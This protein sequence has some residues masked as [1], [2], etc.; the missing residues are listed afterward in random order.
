MTPTGQDSPMDIFEAAK[1]HAD[2]TAPAP[3]D[4]PVAAA[5][6]AT[7]FGLF[8]IGVFFAIRWFGVPEW[9]AWIAA[10]AIYGLIAYGDCRLGWHHH[11]RAYQQRLADLRAETPARSLH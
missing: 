5:L 6:T 7:A 2:G 4:R 10:A 9:V 11:R 8:V 3:V 1:A